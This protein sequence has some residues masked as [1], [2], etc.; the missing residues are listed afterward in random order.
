MIMK[1]NLRS[2]L[3]ATI[4]LTFCLIAESVL[5]LEAPLIG[6]AYVSG[7]STTVNTNYGTSTLLYINGATSGTSMRRRIWVQFDVMRAIPAGMTA[8]DITSATLRV[9]AV[10][11][12]TGGAVGAFA[13][14]TDFGETTVNATRLGTSTV[15]DYQQITTSGQFVNFDVTDLVKEWVSGSRRNDGIALVAVTG[16]TVPNITIDSKE[17]TTTSHA[18]SLH[19]V[20][21]GPE[22][23]AGPQGVQGPVGPKGDAGV[24][25]PQGATGPAGPVGA[26]GMT[27]P[28]GAPGAAGQNGKTLISGTEDPSGSI[29]VDG[30]FYV[31]T[32]TTTLFGPKAGGTWPA[33][34]SLIG[35][36][37][38]QGPPTLRIAP[39]GDISMGEFT[40][41]PA[42][43]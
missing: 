11:V 23:P 28:Q 39:R 17:N 4:A 35:P 40:Q 24:A 34:L 29:G 31:N 6:D 14:V 2:P 22:G 37:G 9:Y 13:A 20:L 25:G 15:Y 30:D 43:P 16:T 21:R 42:A 12:T 8:A 32:S 3:A 36:A 19:L 1:S 10:T 26:T 7:A 27:G 38:P 5:A 18:P 33:G 41:G